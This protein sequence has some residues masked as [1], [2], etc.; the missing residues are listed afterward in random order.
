MNKKELSIR[1]V[2]SIV[3]VL[4]IAL[5]A[6]TLNVGNVGV[7][8]FTASNIAIGRVFNLSLGTYQILINCIF[9]IFIFFFG[10]KYIGIGTFVT[11]FS[12]GALVDVFTKL[13]SNMVFF[14][15]N[16]FMKIIF[17]I[18]GTGLFTFGVAFY[19]SANIG[20]APFDAITLILTDYSKVKYKYIRILQDL[21]FM[22]SAIVLMGPVGI[23]TII[24]AFFNG[25]LIEFWHVKISSPLIKKL[26]NI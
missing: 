26:L 14:E 7:D 25:P 24:N 3:G 10:R 20:V 1:I 16:F 6:A 15:L 5:G 19:I 9:L 2:F 22:F 11:M 17:L 23:G 12:I 13:I 18:L 4:I 8:T 21:L